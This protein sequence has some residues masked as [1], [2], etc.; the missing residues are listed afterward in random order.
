MD[1]DPPDALAF[2]SPSQYSLEEDIARAEVVFDEP[3]SL[4]DDAAPASSYFPPE[5][6][7]DEPLSV[8]VVSPIAV[9]VVMTSSAV[10]TATPPLKRAS[11]RVSPRVRAAQG[12]PVISTGPDVPLPAPALNS[13]PENDDPVTPGRNLRPKRALRA[14][15]ALKQQAKRRKKSTNVAAGVTAPIQRAMARR[16]SVNPNGG[17]NPVY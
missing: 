14:M 6:R 12:A 13:M 5:T 17:A 1:A 7:R 2:S 9:D 8:S 3:E 10:M 11:P 4:L 15:T 16:N